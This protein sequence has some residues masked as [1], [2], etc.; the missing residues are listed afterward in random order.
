MTLLIY[1]ASL[2]LAEIVIEVL[3]S[4][5]RRALRANTAS[6]GVRPS[7]FRRKVAVP[8]LPNREPLA[9]V[10]SEIRGAYWGNHGLGNRDQHITRCGVTPVQPC[11]L[12][13]TLFKV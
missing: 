7:H 2:A 11:S 8:V 9:F 13:N 10:Q 4:A 12:D 3:I 6:F 1:A 5:L